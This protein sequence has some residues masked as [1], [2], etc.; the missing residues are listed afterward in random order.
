MTSRWCRIIVLILFLTL[1][2][3]VFSEIDVNCL[4]VYLSGKPEGKNITII[5]ADST[6]IRGKLLKIDFENSLLTLRSKVFAD[7]GDSTFSF[8]QLAG[9]QG[10]TRKVGE[11][12]GG[13]MTLGF[14]GGALIG[15]S[16]G[17][18]VQDRDKMF[19]Y[20]PAWGLAIGGVVGLAAG[21]FIPMISGN[22]SFEC[23]TAQSKGN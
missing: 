12:N 7:S 15:L 20:S 8:S 21:T 10:S 9:L 11:L 16:I 19:D 4:R 1:P 5:T 6:L 17:F 22:K 2:Q 18:S 3:Q 23:S 13:Y 14:L